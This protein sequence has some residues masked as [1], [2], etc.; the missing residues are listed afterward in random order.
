MPW[1]D[2][3]RYAPWLTRERVLRWS[4]GFVLLSV[5]LATAHIV[6]RTTAG[7]TNQIGEHLGGD[8]INYWLGAP[9]AVERRLPTTLTSLMP[10]RN[11]WSDR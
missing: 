3:L 5:I 6:S 8:F 2:T 10:S 7:L 1:I 9:T 4:L 11:R